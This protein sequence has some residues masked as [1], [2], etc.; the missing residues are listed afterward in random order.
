VLK[1]KGLEM[2]ISQVKDKLD[3][4]VKVENVVKQIHTN[5]YFS[6]FGIHTLN[7]KTL[8]YIKNPKHKRKIKLILVLNKL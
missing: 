5:D 7:E 3:Q 6:I 8:E 4:L 2:Q 1:I